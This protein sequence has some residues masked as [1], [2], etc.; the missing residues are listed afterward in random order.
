VCDELGVSLPAAALQFPLAH[1]ASVTVVSG[2]RNAQQLTSNIEWFEQ[3]IPDEFWSE[4]QKRGLISEGAPVP[5][6]KA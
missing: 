5:G 3:A 6:T 2:A 1:P 4:L